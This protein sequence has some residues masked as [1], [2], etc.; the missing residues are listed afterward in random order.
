[1]NFLKI[2]MIMKNTIDKDYH[3]DYNGIDTNKL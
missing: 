2:L 1:M 3:Y